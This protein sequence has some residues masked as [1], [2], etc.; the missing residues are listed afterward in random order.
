MSAVVCFRN[1]RREIGRRLIVTESTS[2]AL[3]R[4]WR[5]TSPGRT[6]LVYAFPMPALR[7]RFVAAIVTAAIQDA[8]G[9]TVPRSHNR[10]TFGVVG[11]GKVVATDNGD[12]TSFEPFASSSRE[13]F[14]G[15]A[16][17]IVR[18]ARGATGSVR[19]IAAADELKAGTITVRVAR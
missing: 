8:N 19:I 18:P 9:L 6:K 12:P 7:A 11:P 3:A 4:T 17:A 14:N 16:V 1:E 13:A 15:L 5:E 10:L 2:F